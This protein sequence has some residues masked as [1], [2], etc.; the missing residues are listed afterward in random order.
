MS[1]VAPRPRGK[2]R[3]LRAE[4]ERCDRRAPGAWPVAGLVAAVS[5][6]GVAGLGLGA[7]SRQDVWSRIEEAAAAAGV[8]PVR[9]MVRGHSHTSE[10]DIAAALALDVVRSQLSFDAETARGRIEAL[11]WVKSAVVG[12]VLPDGVRVDI[13]E[14]R[15]AAVW[16][17]AD[18]DLLVDTEGRVLTAIG[19]GAHTGLPLLSGHGAANALSAIMALVT[20][21]AEIERRL[22][23]LI[24]VEDRRWTLRLASGTLLLLPGD[25]AAAALAWADAEARNGLLDRGGLAIDL[26]VAG[27]LL[28][29]DG[30]KTAI[31][32]LARAELQGPD[33][34]RSGP[35]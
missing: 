9:L 17:G 12:R 1:P 19:R 14:R 32:R 18:Q 13:S 7:P 24:R 11:P 35:P 22:V 29:R 28:I 33:A 16:Q 2:V 27:Q 8:K 3:R 23:E 25:G 30:G 6:A 4:R 10:A 31:D 26:R 21:H 20:S 15:P 34:G 5:L